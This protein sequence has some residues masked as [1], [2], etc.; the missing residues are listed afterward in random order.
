MWCWPKKDTGN[1]K[2]LIEKNIYIQVTETRYKWTWLNSGYLVE[3]WE[4]SVV[5]T[6][7]P[8]CK[9]YNTWLCYANWCTG[10]WHTPH[11]VYVCGTRPVI[12]WVLLQG[13]SP[14]TSSS[15]KL[16][17]APSV[18]PLKG[19]PQATGE[20]P[21]ALRRGLKPAGTPP[22]ARGIS[23]DEAHPTRT[24]QCT[25]R[26]ADVWPN[27]WRVASKWWLVHF[28][29]RS[30][31]RVFMACIYVG[32]A[33]NTSSECWL[34]CSVS[35]IEEIPWICYHLSFQSHQTP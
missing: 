35:N 26:L 1:T 29:W 16:H 12:R 28:V 14:D 34:F 13:R 33:K 23:S 32:S 25:T 10:I 22:E 24:L 20:E 9:W 27:K 18:F 4:S 6:I 21:N 8:L 2:G 7:C 3:S 17:R 30:R 19:V 31:W 11:Q 15:P 5:V